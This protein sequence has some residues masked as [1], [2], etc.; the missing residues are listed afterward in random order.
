[1]NGTG[2]SRRRT[3]FHCYLLVNCC[4]WNLPVVGVGLRAGSLSGYFH[5]EILTVHFNFYG[6]DKI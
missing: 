2:K 6:Y 1:M 4:F 5:E 3:A